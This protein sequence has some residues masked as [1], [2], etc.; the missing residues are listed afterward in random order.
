MRGAATP[1]RGRRRSSSTATRAKRFGMSIS[2]V[3]MTMAFSF[4]GRA[5]PWCAT[6]KQCVARCYLRQRP[7]REEKALQMRPTGTQIKSHCQ[8]FSSRLPGRLPRSGENDFAREKITPRK[9]KETSSDP[10]NT[11][12]AGFNRSRRCSMKSCAAARRCTRSATLRVQSAAARNGRVFSTAP[13]GSPASCS[14]HG[15]K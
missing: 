7:R 6:V 8:R 12:L 15:R 14:V 11:G 2:F 13:M 9:S 4:S 10:D 1:A 3:T 5:S